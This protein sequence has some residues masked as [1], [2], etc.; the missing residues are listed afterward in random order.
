MALA[1][2]NKYCSKPC[3]YEAR[4]KRIESAC[5]HCGKII[6]VTPS[7]VGAGRGRYCGR[8][9]LA[10]QTIVLTGARFKKGVRPSNYKGFTN[11]HG[12]NADGYILIFLPEHPYTNSQ[13]YVREHRLV[14]EKHI[15]RYLTPEEIIHHKDFNK[16][17][18]SIENL[19]IMTRRE[20]DAYH[21]RVRKG[22]EFV[23][24]LL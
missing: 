2:R 22:G 13:G 21:A 7:R 20:H 8:S 1:Q 19:Q 5:L 17:N 6:I 15:G 18:N 9:C 24:P 16:T 3:Q 11:T 23:V 14:M 10:H 4:R 12:K